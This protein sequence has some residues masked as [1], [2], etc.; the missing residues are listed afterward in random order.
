[1]HKNAKLLSVEQK[2]QQIVI[3]KH[4]S[5]LT[6]SSSIETLEGVGGGNY[7]YMT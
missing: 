4:V 1:M 7:L 5:P 3:F 2:L 6:S